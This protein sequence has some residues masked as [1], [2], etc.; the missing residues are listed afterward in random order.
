[1]SYSIRTRLHHWIEQCPCTNFLVKNKKEQEQVDGIWYD[2]VVVECLVKAEEQQSLPHT[3]TD[4]SKKAL[5][6][7]QQRILDRLE[8]QP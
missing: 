8:D 4:T 2:V 6:A 5:D 7:M 1:M 3:P